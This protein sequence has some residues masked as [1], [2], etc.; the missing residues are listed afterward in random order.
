MM[1]VGQ[2]MME[3]NIAE[4]EKTRVAM[5]RDLVQKFI[6]KQCGGRDCGWKQP[7]RGVDRACSDDEAGNGCTV[8]PTARIR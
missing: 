5:A 1:G 7:Q 3:R 2:D 4:K 6:T 8:W